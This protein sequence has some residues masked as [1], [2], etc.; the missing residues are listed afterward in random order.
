MSKRPSAAQAMAERAA[1]LVDL[2]EESE[3]PS[4]TSPP[5]T[6]AP[7]PGGDEE[8]LIT[9]PPAAPS[10]VRKRKPGRPRRARQVAS[11]QTV[12]LD[13]PRHDALVQIAIDDDRSMHAVILDALDKYIRAKAKR[14]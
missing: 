13:E 5:P 9:L 11:K 10:N 12:Y 1:R 14:R 8:Q 4:P 3:A 6:A 7:P 2:A